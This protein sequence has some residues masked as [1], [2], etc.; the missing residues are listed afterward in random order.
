MNIEAWIKDA[1][2][3]YATQTKWGL[4]TYSCDVFYYTEEPIDDL[5]YVIC[6]I[7][8]SNG[9]IYDKVS[10]GAILGFSMLDQD[11][12]N[13]RKSY[14]DKAEVQLFDQILKIAESNHLIEVKEGYVYL[15]N[16]G[17]ISLE[18]EKIFKFYQG[19]KPL[20]EHL[21]LKS[22]NENLEMFPFF[23][24]MGIFSSVL[25]SHVIW[26]DD[27]E[28]EAIIF[29][30]PNDLSKRMMLQS[31]IHINFYKVLQD[32]YFDQ[33]IIELQVKLFKKGDD[34]LPV[35]INGANIASF[36]SSIINNGLNEIKKEQ[37]IL[38]TLFQKLWDDNSSI[39]DYK[40]LKPYF[41]LVNYEDLTKDSRT[42]WSDKLL[43][44]QIIKRANPTCWVNITSHCDL[45]ILYDIVPNYKDKLNWQ[46]LSKRVEDQFLYEHFLEY[47]WDLEVLSE[48]SER[49]DEIIEKLILIKK[50]TI[51]DWNWD[52]LGSRLSKEFIFNHLDVVQVDLSSYTRDSD[53][54]RSLILKYPNKRWDYERIENEFGL[55][56][57]LNNIDT[58]ENNF[59]FEPLFERVFTD[60][61][62]ADKFATDSSFQNV[63]RDSVN[64]EGRLSSC[65]FNHKDY[66]WSDS[67]IDLFESTNL[68]VWESTQYTKGFECNPYLDWSM[69]FFARYHSFISTD[70]G[71]KHVSCTIGN[72]DI[73]ER[74]TDFQWNW[75]AISSNE[76]LLSD[77]KLY[78]KFGS[79]LNWSIVFSVNHDNELL[80]GIHNLNELIA[81]DKEAWN[82]FS[83]F[84]DVSYIKKHYQFDWD[85]TVLTERMFQNLKLDKIGSPNFIDKWDWTYLSNHVEIDFLNEHLSEYRSY[86][87][88][89]FVLP[90]ILD[91]TNRLDADFLDSM[92]A[93]LSKIPNAEKRK[94]AWSALTSQYN[95]KELKELLKTTV[96]KRNYWWDMTYFCQH[97]DFNVYEDL[98]DCRYSIDWDI[99]SSSEVVDRNFTYVPGLKIKQSEWIK[100]ALKVLS[101]ERNKW[102]F[103]LL[104]HFESLRNQRWFV[105]RFKDSLDWTA[106]SLE[107]TLFAE[108]D[109][110][111]L[112]EIITEYKELIDYHALSQRDDVNIQQVMKINPVG[113]Y[114]YNALM[115]RQAIDVTTELVENLDEYE[116][117]WFALTSINGFFP[118]AK[119]LKKHINQNINWGFISS[120]DIKRAWS[121]ND[122]LDTIAINSEISDQIDWYS[123]SSR[124]YFPISRDLLLKLIT[125]NLNWKQL[126]RRSQIIEV[127]DDYTD[128]VD[129][130]EVSRIGEL[131]VNEFMILDKYRDRLDWGVICSRSD[132][133]ITNDV[134]NRYAD[135][136]DWTVASR[137]KDIVFSID[138]VEKYKDRWNWPE[139]IRNR[140]FNNVVNISKLPHVRSNNII[141]FV[142]SFGRHKPTAYHFTHISNA[143]KI[144]QTMKL[145]CRNYADGNFTNSAGSNVHRTAKAHRFARFYFAPKSPTQFYNE[146]LGKDH[147]DGYYSKAYKLGLPK[148][149]MPV[150]FIFDVEELLMSMPDLCYYSTGNMQKDCTRWYRVIEDPSQIKAS[151]IFDPPSRNNFAERQQEFLVDGELDFSSL[152]NVQICCCNE[153]QAEL[154][155]AEV[156]GSKWED[157]IKVKT[158]LYEFQN[159]ELYFNDSEDRL[160]I[161]TDYD[162]PFEFKVVFYEEMPEIINK[163]NVLRQIGHNIYLKNTVEVQK[164]S[165]FD[166]YFEVHSPRKESWLI[167]SNH[168]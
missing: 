156:R 26:P 140:A 46:E 101:D 65:L 89:S 107:S 111:K 152:N 135:K 15:T 67:V 130:R 95:F 168:K 93:M 86:W 148:C 160:H 139:L 40:T 142:Q 7:L 129:W 70:E 71:R 154:L 56:Y 81:D 47:P 73:L 4:K 92:A 68:I 53:Q 109:K 39:L 57:I 157:M 28:V 51:D 27:E 151:A 59:L 108:T 76:K 164:D 11:L 163:N 64:D 50:D 13:G 141:R 17:R 118:S 106:I 113:N 55:D 98:D 128:Y 146:F 85:W 42:V 138:L 137:S 74:F 94:A 120:Q 44:R 1:E 9:V 166:V 167:Y 103:K 3:V 100:D 144:I 16:L 110:Q 60:E 150:F 99:L 2:Y 91:E 25:S 155:R 8:Q 24:D 52:A 19:R 147:L 41:E 34:Y 43:F 145:Q 131:Q 72:V 31:D 14:Y 115:A 10:L 161:S 165:D 49:S 143:V 36:V 80:Q 124:N 134:L 18:K 32:E 97:P 77:S 61:E 20:Y 78:A 54:I 66:R 125:R 84:A 69:D 62:W 33:K 122:L 22:D 132:F 23:E 82:A 127:L 6:S 79:D 58:F 29:N 159:K 153:Y 45:S 88:W 149:P 162:N 123:L 21:L 119:F 38:E 126:S 37:L 96:R 48:D 5:S 75:D 114:D 104:S 35:I 12:G 136:I 117:D 158:S 116:W 90:R 112:N 133:V 83:T 30:E 121:D 87:D 63:V 102:N 105:S